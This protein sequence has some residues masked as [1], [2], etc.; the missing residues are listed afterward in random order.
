MDRLSI[1]EIIEKIEIGERF[2]S[3]SSSG[4]F[5]IIV[6]EYVPYICFAIHNGG[7]FRT[8][9]REKLNISKME[10]W[11]EEDP[12]TWRFIESLPLR[13]VVHDSRYEYDLNRTPEDALYDT[14]WGKKVWKSQLSEEEKLYSLQKH[15]DF[16]RV[17]DTLVLKLEN[18]FGGALIYDIHSY[19]FKKYGGN[20]DYPTFNIGTERIDPKYRKNINKFLKE[21]E[22][23]DLLP[24]YNRVAENEVFFGRGYLL[25]HI[26]SKFDKSLVYAVEIKKI[27]VDEESGDEY[28]DIIDKIG[29][30]LKKAILNTSYFFVKKLKISDF[31]VKYNLLSSISEDYLHDIDTQI[32]KLL[33]GLD[34]LKHVNPI[35][36]NS[37]KR[38]FFSSKNHEI[39][40]R[41]KPTSIDIKTA[42]RKLLK[43]QLEKINDLTL[44]TLYGDIIEV[45]I[46]K[47]ELIETINTPEFL[48]NSIRV[49]GKPTA[50]DLA[51][52]EYI[53]HSAPLNEDD[54][55]L[56]S[57]ETKEV[58]EKIISEY[59]LKCNVKLSKTISANAMV[60]N[61][62]KTILIKADEVFTKSYAEALGHHE[63]GIHILTTINASKSNLKILH[64]GTP[65]NTK[66][67]E[68]LAILNEYLSGNL[69][70][71]R[72][73]ELALRVIAVDLFIKEN[74]F[75]T[76]YEKLI[77]KYGVSEDKSFQI[78]TRVWRAGG[79]TKD[80]LYLKGFIE[81]LKLYQKGESLEP[82]L[83][84]KISV[85][86][87]E[88]IK[89]L[90]ARG[91]L[92]RP[93]HTP[94]TFEEPLKKENL[95]LEYILKSL[96]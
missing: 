17:V 96:K 6:E 5:S 24:L 55:L 65:Q 80:Y 54:T 60:L 86:Y 70:L 49:F 37:E 19:N 35:N 72:L 90:M 52:A 67:Q 31:S 78:V 95:I 30:G 1:D 40:F 82:L 10:R 8:E 91:V 76:I 28:P 22:K 2:S 64:I 7:N 61:S 79:F 13:I 46:K 20:S 48:L 16:Y 25:S 63:A 85:E 12:Y 87:R 9:L 47:L 69:T 94:K 32:S 43:V 58:V 42:K 53:L 15:S 11:H 73:R 41:Y 38:K 59:G 50:K 44:R 77:S 34:V 18:D 39:E 3:I 62:S 71:E 57:K 68:G 26:M 89:E 27:Y 75:R 45:A 93:H 81:V 56:S 23:I 36:F 14:A 83:L 4:S 29:I 66:T 84:G 21:L 88:S 33:K 51:N 92:N 74:D